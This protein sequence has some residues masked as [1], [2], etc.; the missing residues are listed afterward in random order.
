MVSSLP[1]LRIKA[2]MCKTTIVDSI[3]RSLPL[4]WICGETD[5]LSKL[6]LYPPPEGRGFT[7]SL[8]KI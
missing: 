4:L 5:F 7:A 3:N 6:A 2:L 8:D 1:V